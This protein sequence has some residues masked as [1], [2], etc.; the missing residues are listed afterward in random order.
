[1]EGRGRWRGWV[2]EWCL[3]DVVGVVTVASRRMGQGREIADHRDT[4]IPN[5]GGRNFL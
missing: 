3:L 1:M 2:E 4:E 5:L